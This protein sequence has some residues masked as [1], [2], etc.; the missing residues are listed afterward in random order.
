MAFSAFD[1][2]TAPPGEEAI[3]EALG[4]AH[5]WWDELR[6][7]LSSAW[8]PYAEVWGF[9]SRTTGWG[10]RVKHGERVI[11]YL[12][13][14]QGEFLAS[15]ALGERAVQDALARG[16][17]DAFV[18]IV[19]GAR[20]YAEGRAVRVTVTSAADVDAVEKLALAKAGLPA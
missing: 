19:A 13:P 12:T 2:K 18:E 16:L 5:A 1:D 3:A 15:F 4:P 20:R 7:R 10:L 9:T 14:R 17:P 11:V 6:G 8:H